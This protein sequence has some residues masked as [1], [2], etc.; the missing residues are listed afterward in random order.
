MTSSYKGRCKRTDARVLP[1]CHGDTSPVIS[2]RNQR[3]AVD[4]QRGDKAWTE[5]CCPLSTR[6]LGTRRGEEELRDVKLKLSLQ[7]CKKKFLDK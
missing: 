5:D 1:G 4:M 7:Y 6:N 3:T 2:G